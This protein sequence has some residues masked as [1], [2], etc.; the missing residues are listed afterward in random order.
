MRTSGLAFT[1]ARTAKVR[2][3][4]STRKYVMD[5]AKQANQPA[6]A[7][8]YAAADIWFEVIKRVDH[9]TLSQ[10]LAL[11]EERRLHKHITGDN[12]HVKPQTGTSPVL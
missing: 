4:H 2:R 11:A 6:R 5:A 9:S 12:R 7:A 1:E 8:Y 10:C 3:L